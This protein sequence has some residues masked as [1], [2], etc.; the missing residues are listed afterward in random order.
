MQRKSDARRSGHLA[1]IRGLVPAACGRALAPC[2]GAGFPAA[3]RPNV[4]RGCRIVPPLHHLLGLWALRI[5]IDHPPYMASGLALHRGVPL[6]QFAPCPRWPVV[7]DIFRCRSSVV[8]HPF[9]KVFDAA[10]IFLNQKLSAIAKFGKPNS[11]KRSRVCRCDHTVTQPSPPT[12]Q[13]QSGLR[14]LYGRSL[15]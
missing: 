12:T 15:E 1:A 3:P 11:F 2:D 10:N 7:A 4:C 5:I 13:A 6:W 9:G 8:E 14:R